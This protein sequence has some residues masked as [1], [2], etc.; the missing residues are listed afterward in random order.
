MYTHTPYS[1]CN[2]FLS[3]WQLKYSVDILARITELMM[4]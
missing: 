1:Y 2:S 4:A 3:S